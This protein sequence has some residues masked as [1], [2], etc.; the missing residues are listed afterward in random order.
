MGTSVVC[1]NDVEPR[2]GNERCNCKRSDAPAHETGLI[3]TG[4]CLILDEAELNSQ[5]LRLRW[6]WELEELSAAAFFV[7][8]VFLEATV[9]FF[10]KGAAFLTLATFFA[11]LRAVPVVP[12]FLV[13]G[14]SGANR[15]LRE[16]LT[17]APGSSIS[18][19]VSQLSSSESSRSTSSMTGGGGPIISAGQAHGGCSVSGFH[20]SIGS[21]E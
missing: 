16:P 1:M 20:T 3:A 13:P 17:S 6:V 4:T 9:P 15:T 8:K 5:D 19:S 2:L 18:T 10:T 21:T 12:R 11:G 7:F 14:G